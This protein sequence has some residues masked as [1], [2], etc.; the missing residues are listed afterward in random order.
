MFLEGGFCWWALPSVGLCSLQGEKATHRIITYDVEVRCYISCGL[1][2]NVWTHKR[3][4]R[5]NDSD[6][7]HW[8]E[9]CYCFV[10]K[11]VWVYM[12]LKIGITN[13]RWSLNNIDHSIR[14]APWM[15]ANK[16]TCTY[17]S[18]RQASRFPHS[19]LK[20]SNGHE[21]P[22]YDT[23]PWMVKRTRIQV[24]GRSPIDYYSGLMQ[25]VLI[26]PMGSALRLRISAFFV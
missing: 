25:L 16:A 23:D 18:Q 13:I 4:I 14:W 10:L 21:Y 9:F 8:H 26:G 12:Y 5:R 20:T 17:I 22:H 19:W 7:C 11:L 3:E 2:N 6:V 1:A 24:L 15:S